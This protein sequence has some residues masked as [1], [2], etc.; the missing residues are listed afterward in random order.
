MAAHSLL[1]FIALPHKSC[2]GRTQVS[3]P[4]TVRYRSCRELHQTSLMCGPTNRKDYTIS[5]HVIWR[6]LVVCFIQSGCESKTAGK[7]RLRVSIVRVCI[8]HLIFI[9]Q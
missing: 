9:W 6:E 7:R 3:C 5:V 8:E 1:L 4:F 2:H